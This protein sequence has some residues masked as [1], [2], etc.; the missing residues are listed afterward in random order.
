MRRRHREA[1]PT[2]RPRPRLVL[3]LVALVVATLGAASQATAQVATGTYVG[4]GSM[5]RRIQ[6]VGF[7]PAL[8]IV[9][10]D[11]A[12]AA[13]ARS[14]GMPSVSSQRLADI[15][16]A[17]NNGVMQLESDGFRLGNAP[18]VNQPGVRYHWIAFAN[19]PG[20]IAVGTYTGN[21]SASRTIGSL[22]LTPSTVLLIPGNASP[23]LL[24]TATMP[25]G[26]AAPLGDGMLQPGA[27]T[28]L[29]ADG[30]TVSSDANAGGV[31][32]HYL[33]V[34]GSAGR[35]A[36]GDYVGDG[37]PGRAVDAAG[38]RPQW[39]LVKSAAGHQAVHQTS[40]RAGSGHTLAMRAAADFAGGIEQFTSLGFSLG[41]HVRVN[42][43]AGTYY[44]AALTSRADLADLAVTLTT[45]T[46]T[47]ELGDVV[48]L[49]TTARNLG[50]D[51][52][53]AVSLQLDLPAGLRLEGLVAPS[54]TLADYSSPSRIHVVYNLAAG[55]ERT[56]TAALVVESGH[57]TR[58]AT[59][60]T[61]ATVPDPSFANNEA[62]VT[63]TIPSA[64]LAVSLAAADE[65]PYAGGLAEVCVT[66]ANQ[67]PDAALDASV[68][69]SLP[70]GLALTAASP[71]VGVYEAGTNTWHVG[72][73]AAGFSAT[74]TLTLAIDAD[75]AGASLV[76]GAT[77]SALRNDPA[78]ADN[79][80]TTT[81]SIAAAPVAQVEVFAVTFPQEHRRLLP[82][83]PADD[84]LGLRLVNTGPLARTVAAIT[85][86]NLPTG[87]LDQ[88]SQDALWDSVSLRRRGGQTLATGL[89]E[90]GR[91]AVTGLDLALA[92]GDTLVLI[93][94]GKAA[95]AARDGVLL[96]PA[97]AAADDVVFDA[98][99]VHVQGAWPTQSPG[100]LSVDGMTAAQI[101]LTPIGPEVFQLGSERN[102][103]LDVLIPGNGGQPDI[104]TKLNVENLGDAPDHS[105]VR[106]VEAWV[107]DGDGQFDPVSDARIGQLY[108]TGGGRYEASALAV[109][110][111]GAGLRVLVTVDIAGDAPGGTVR[112][113]LP[114]GDDVAINVASD[115]DGPIDA[116]VVNPY[117][118]TIS[119]TDRVVLTTAPIAARH[120]APGEERVPLLHVV[121][122]NLH[123]ET[124][125]LRRVQVRNVTRGAQGASQAD[126][127]GTVYQLFL[128]LDGNGNGEV[129]GPQIDPIVGTASWQD[130][131]AV[132][133]GLDVPL[134]AGATGRVFVT[135][136]VAL[137]GA[138]DGDSLGLVVAGPADIGLANDAALVGAWPLD[139]GA[140]HRVRGMVAAQVTSP[141]V[142]AVSLAAGEG[143]VL[144]LD[145]FLPANGYQDDVLRDV[146]LTNQGN[147]S[148]ADI[149]ALQLWADSGDGHFDP[150]FDTLLGT[151]TNVGQDWLALD[152]DLAVPV[153]G[154]R[155]FVSVTA[156]ITP[157]DSAAVRLAI[158]AGGLQM[159]STND[160]PL[161]QSVIGATTL[162]IS[163]APLL[164]SLSFDAPRST[165]EMNVTAS[166]RVVNVGAERVV[167]IVPGDLTMN[168]TGSL[169]VVGGPEPFSLELEPGEVGTFVWQF[170]P[171]ATGAVQIAARCGGVGAVGGQPRV[172]L[173][174]SS[175]PHR[176]LAP[177]HDLGLYPQ[178][179]LPFSINRGQTGLVPLIL[180]LVNDGGDEAAELRVQR[181]VITLD[182]GADQPVAPASLLSRV[183][184]NEGVRLYC[185][186]QQLESEGQTMT[187]DLSPAVVITG[188]EPT[189]LSLRLDIRGDAVPE[190]FRVG[191]A[192][193]DALVVVD[194]ISGLPRALDL[195]DGSFPVRTGVGAIVA[196]ATGLAV[197]AEPLA[198][199]TAGPGQTGVE[200]MRLLLDGLG[201]ASSSEVKVG[202]FAITVRDTL[203][204]PLA[205]PAALLERLVV[206]GPLAVHAARSL[207][208]A[209][210]SLLVLQLTPP[211]TVPAGAP[212]VPI[213]VL[214]DIAGA[215]LLGNVRLAMAGAHL[216]DAR[217]GNTSSPVPVTFQQPA[218]SGPAVIIQAAAPALR[219]AV[220]PRLPAIVPQGGRDLAA[221]DVTVA[222]P[223]PTSTAAVRLDALRL[224]CLD[225]DRQ[226]QDP[227]LAIDAARIRVGASG[228]LSANVDGPDLVAPLGGVSLLPGE[229]ITIECRVDLAAA[230][231]AALELILQ[232]AGLT[233]R[234]ANLDVAVGVEPAA[235]QVLPGSSGLGRLQGASTEVLIAWTDRL[236]ALLPGDEATT[237]AAHVELRNPAPASAAPL[238]LTS[239]TLRA[240]DA[241]GA[242][243]AAGSVI[244]TAAAWLDGQP[245][246][247]AVS[248]V[249]ADSVIVLTGAT[250]LLLAPTTTRTLELR[251]AGRLL[252][253]G[254]SVR[255][256]LREGDVVCRQPGGGAAVPVRAVAGQTWPFWTAPAGLVGADL[257]A[258]YIN[259][260]NPFAA[261]RE[262][263][264][265]AFNLARPATVSLALWTPRGERVVVLL[266]ERA[267]VAGLHQDVSWD[268]RNGRGQAVVNG[269]Y[270]AELT[271]RYDDGDRERLLRKVAV[272]R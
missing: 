174:T 55:D 102:L 146:R 117:T 37:V 22:G 271:V 106:R 261:G 229:Q 264:S 58:T 219:V 265:F 107:D 120:V 220:S 221:M 198:P 253:P 35:A 212:S 68:A 185:D 92:A 147:A 262:A 237:T 124:Q 168:G 172:S 128:Q 251:I 159:A 69:I 241:D 200:M 85:L 26:M 210:D 207:S 90:Q 66:L 189:T 80:A 238:E 183:T 10:G 100:T 97:L 137:F 17:L 226:P 170:A 186:R 12:A 78:P 233:A 99:E 60:M 176:I 13:V 190:R 118:Q 235:G 73:L 192:G 246:A 104:L 61:T 199:R 79:A 112:L 53:A 95:L 42:E 270:L 119:A 236:P 111:P 84:V 231:G 167:G 254:T 228:P 217:D 197:G 216:V 222:H 173:A 234:D 115:N 81:L 129:D 91:F 155:V 154:R 162:L 178:T 201:D 225:A 208:G 194:D 21:G 258:S 41:D 224:T 122:R 156:A 141:P 15:A 76:V 144:A 82:G 169:T 213:S 87:D 138:A 135:G 126:L 161:D 256:G 5:A 227:R 127:D 71:D 240:A 214:G 56:I 142:P 268:G 131:V 182:D 86:S 245:W 108:W 11:L 94:S 218:P 202:A 203:G 171:T 191:L 247:V 272:V 206:R 45:D 180:T 24:R 18:E 70:A 248:V 266:D 49:S 98:A 152:V 175:A 209:A 163:T 257:A 28:G 196:Q 29:V 27:L 6:G 19:D 48:T 125:V 105:A 52:A 121:A 96:V 263:T 116:A 165:T 244:A 43:A 88:A 223:G 54:D 38:F 133:E 34:A 252:A 16:E 158:P 9:K 193:P 83:G 157:T 250:P 2:L 134:A 63:L 7:V 4:N 132:F 89:F 109:P 1:R 149:Q 255:L 230:D 47:V 140:R 243:L 59:A 75:Q 64:D 101:V 204:Q 153:G 31:N 267:L 36:T 123:A 164:S 151:L 32:Y 260:P 195:L 160:G 211:I 77:A 50:P 179:S 130:G 39:V 215:G 259:F 57:A 51:P 188:R 114:A 33:A 40:E 166:M 23:S 65:H 232:A 239:L 181:L 30:F 177:A 14:S 145:L 139:S 93:L 113:S 25:A 148:G 242:R 143:P 205:D 46:P 136:H 20:E 187:L 62:S 8:V 103:A 44:W 184:V 269:V 3:T 67:G 150:G 249:E 110:I 74:L 72:A